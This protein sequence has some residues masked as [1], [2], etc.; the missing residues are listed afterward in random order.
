MRSSESTKAI[1]EA[2]M[3]CLAGLEN[4]PKT[5]DVKAGAVRYSF[6]PLPD[7][8]DKVRPQ[9]G[10]CGLALTMEA[11]SENGNAGAAARLTHQSGEWI[12]YGPLLLPAGATAQTAGSAITYARRYLLCAILNIAADED[13]DGAKASKSTRKPKEDWGSKVEAP[14][15]SA[16]EGNLG[17]GSD[18]AESTLGETPGGATVTLPGSPDELDDNPAP[19]WLWHEAESA[20][21]SGARALRAAVANVKAGTMPGP[22]PKAQSDITGKQLAMLIEGLGTK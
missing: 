22:A 8:L 4:P 14:K 7:I 16:P 1:N 11:V 13:D 3:L 19:N 6:A 10:E 18:G 15:V 17:E 2:L 12:E 21:L 5:E 20:G 9:L